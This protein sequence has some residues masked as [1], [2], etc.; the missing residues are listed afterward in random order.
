MYY[1]YCKKNGKRH[2]KG[3]DNIIEFGGILGDF[4]R[5]N[6]LQTDFEGK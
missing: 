6:M 5:K 3:G 2:C 4:K 1:N